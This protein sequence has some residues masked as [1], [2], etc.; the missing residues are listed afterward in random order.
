VNVAQEGLRFVQDVERAGAH[1]AIELITG[2]VVWFREVGDNG[3]ARVGVVDMDDFELCHRIGYRK[4]A[5]VMVGL[6]F[7]TMAV[8]VGPVFV[9]KAIDVVAMKGHTATESVV[10]IEGLGGKREGPACAR[11]TQDRDRRS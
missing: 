9:E 1:Y 11:V 6:K 5:C 3:G 8:N 7:E 10:V 4:T 2:D